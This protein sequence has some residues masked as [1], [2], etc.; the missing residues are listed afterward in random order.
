MATKKVGEQIFFHP[1]C[2]FW[3]RD[4]QKLG[5]EIRDKHPGST[6]DLSSSRRSLQPSRREN[7]ALHNKKCR[8]FSFFWC[9]VGLLGSVSMDSIGSV[10]EKLVLKP[11]N[12]VRHRIISNSKELGI[13]ISIGTRK[14][15]KVL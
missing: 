15:S 8:H 13:L 11:F 1:C 4:G 14:A 12:F 6:K 10:S 7:P 2:Y 5:S 9:H 3:I